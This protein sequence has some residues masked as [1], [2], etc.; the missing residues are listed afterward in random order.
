LDSV[1]QLEDLIIDC[2]YANLLQGK[3][4]QRK[5]AFEVQWVMGRDLGPTEVSDM[6]QTIDLWL[7]HSATLMGM[8]DEKMKHANAIHEKK[9]NEALAMAKQKSDTIE[10]LKVLIAAGDQEAIAL[11]MGLPPPQ[12]G[13]GGD[14]K[15]GRGGSG[16][17]PTGGAAGPKGAMSGML[18]MGGDALRKLTGRRG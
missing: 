2:V 12:G 16:G 6:M 17:R 10:N 7:V 4:D 3:L 9:K 11:A 5:K 1:R 15:G 13:G 8:L 18:A 14:Q